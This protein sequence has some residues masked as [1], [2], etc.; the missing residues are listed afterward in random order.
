MRDLNEKSRRR[1]ACA[2]TGIT[3]LLSWL[4]RRSEFRC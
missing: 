3:L 1:V 4:L 2:A